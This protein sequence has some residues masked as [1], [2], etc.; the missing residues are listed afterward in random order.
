MFGIASR[1]REQLACAALGFRAR[2]E[3]LVHVDRVDAALAQR[4]LGDREADLDQLDVL[5]RID[6]VLLQQQVNGP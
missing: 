6:A 1:Q 3:R 4:V 2:R 5:V